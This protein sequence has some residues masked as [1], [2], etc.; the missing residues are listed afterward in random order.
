M[1]VDLSFNEINFSQG[2]CAVPLKS[3]CA[4]LEK[5]GSLVSNVP[6][7]QYCHKKKMSMQSC[8]FLSPTNCI[9]FLWCH[10]WP[11][12]CSHF[13]CCESSHADKDFT[14][15]M[16]EECS[17]CLLLNRSEK[18]SARR[19]YSQ[20]F[21]VKLGASGAWQPEYRRC[22][23]CLWTMSQQRDTNN[24]RSHRSSREEL[25][26]QF[27]IFWTSWFFY[28]IFWRSCIKMHYFYLHL[29]VGFRRSF[30]LHMRCP[31]TPPPL[32]SIR[33]SV[34][35]QK[36]LWHLLKRPAECSGL[37][38]DPKLWPKTARFLFFSLSLPSK[39]P[40]CTQPS[41]PQ[42]EYVKDFALPNPRQHVH[43]DVS[44]VHAS[45]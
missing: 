31:P 34:R 12:N 22:C 14:D 44:H 21:G 2:M 3:G 26:R 41:T 17:L 24:S 37:K 36:W 6:F 13:I 1:C 18:P 19:R 5:R 9:A 33:L 16:R 42:T 20:R 10:Q 30:S 43:A 15:T 8:D 4:S 23:C 29:P 7:T 11:W 27:R 45:L 28:Q 35:S 39:S 32:W 38:G 40:L 25:N